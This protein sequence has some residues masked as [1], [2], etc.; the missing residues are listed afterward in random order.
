MDEGP[1]KTPNAWAGQLKGWFAKQAAVAEHVPPSEHRTHGARE[2]E[3]LAEIIGQLQHLITLADY[4]VGRP[5]YDPLAIDASNLTTITVSVP[6]GC[7][8]AMLGMS[9][10]S[11]TNVSVTVNAP[12]IPGGSKLV[13]LY[14]SSS[15]GIMGPQPIEAYIPPDC[16]GVTIILGGAQTTAYFMLLFRPVIPGGYPYAG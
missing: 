16:T 4:Y 8:L 7:V 6:T 2:N 14:H 10:T 11:G 9:M 15:S 5:L 13:A 3:Q 1:V 12:S